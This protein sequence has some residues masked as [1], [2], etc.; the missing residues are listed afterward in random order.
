MITK[1][2]VQSFVKILVFDILVIRK[3]SPGITCKLSVCIIS[4]CIPRKTTWKQ[5]FPS[6][7][8]VENTWCVCRVA[9]L[10]TFLKSNLPIATTFGMVKVC[11]YRQS[12]I[13]S[14]NE[15]VT[16]SAFHLISLMRTIETIKLLKDHVWKIL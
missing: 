16:F 6:R 1:L 5:P 13:S 11:F 12:I 10:F 3:L 2:K 14:S 9:S 7:F 15:I 4:F 8:N